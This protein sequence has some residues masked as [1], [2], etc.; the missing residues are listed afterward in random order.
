MKG[1]AYQKEKECV[2][3]CVCVCVARRRAAQPRGYGYGYG[4]G[5]GGG[6]CQGGN[7]APNQRCPMRA[8][9]RLVLLQWR[10]AVACAGPRAPGVAASGPPDCAGSRA[11][12]A[13]VKRRRCFIVFDYG[14]DVRP[15]KCVRREK[16]WAK[17]EARRECGRRSGL[18]GMPC[19]LASRIVR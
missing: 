19:T 15:R 11:L 7:P 3:L 8:S 10:P 2:G 12:A 5:Y 17:G 13:A 18:R 16:R 1:L 14:R 4:Y 6:G 9:C